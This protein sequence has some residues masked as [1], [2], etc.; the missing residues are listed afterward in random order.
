V[1]TR[2][3]QVP[4]KT[5]GD[6]AATNGVSSVPLDGDADISRSTRH[7]PRAAAD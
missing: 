6:R 4:T 2:V 7:I 1:G 3:K 5:E